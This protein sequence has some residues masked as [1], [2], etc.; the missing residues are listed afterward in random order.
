MVIQILI[1]LCVNDRKKTW[2][3]IFLFKNSIS[4]IDLVHFLGSGSKGVDDQCFQTHG[5]FSPSPPSP[6][7]SSLYPPPPPLESK[8][9]WANPS[10]EGQIPARPKSQLW[11]PKR[12]QEA[13]IQT[14]R[15]KFWPQGC[16]LGP[17]VRI[18]ALGLRYWPWG[19][20]LALKTAIWS[21]RL[22][23][24]SQEWD[25]SLEARIWVR[26]GL[27]PFVWKPRS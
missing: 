8:F 18:L 12:N 9:L 10:L 2:F 26:G 27:R 4:T 14:S 15:M 6:T 16:E 24:W 23:F 20:D 17:K 1:N 3:S 11:G 7:S 25:Y 13:Q 21:S 5:E 22:G 19:R